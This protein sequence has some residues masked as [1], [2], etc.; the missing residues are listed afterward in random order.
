[1]RKLL[2]LSALC[3]LL[4][5]SALAS[6][7][8]NPAS[9]PLPTNWQTVDELLQKLEAEATLSASESRQLA[10][11]LRLASSMLSASQTE[12]TELSLLLERSKQS[13]QRSETERLQAQNRSRI[14][15]WTTGI[16]SAVAAVLAAVIFIR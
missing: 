1:M 9:T 10:E 11:R 15:G 12:V 16:A 5:V 6:Q 2:L 14:L 3:A 7:P 13:L 8:V 4:L